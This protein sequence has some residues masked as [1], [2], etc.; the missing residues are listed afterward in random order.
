MKSRFII[1]FLF[2]TSFHLWAD[3]EESQK[4]NINFSGSFRVRG[5]NVGRDVL[6][7]RQTPV[8]RVTNPEAEFLSRQAQ[9]AEAINKDLERRRLG[10]PSELTPRREDISYYDTR[11]LYNMSFSASKYVEGIWGMQVGDI[12]F[13]GKGLRAT[14][15]DGFDPGIIGPGSGGERGRTAAVNVQ[16]NFLYL[17]FRIPEQA[18]FIKVGQQLF[19]SP[20]GRVLFSTGTGVSIVKNFQ[21]LRLVWDVG[22]LR[23]RDQSFLDVDK[24][25]FADKNYQNSNIFYN[26]MK[27]EYFRNIRNEFYAYLLDDNDKTDNETARLGWY[28]LFNEFNFQSFSF[29]VHG[30]L[31]TGTVRKLKSITDTNGLTV[32][33]TRSRHYIK[34]GMYDFQFTYRYSDQLNF[35]LIALGTTGR[36]GYDENGLEANLK[37]NGYRTLAPGFSISNIATDFTGGYALF[38]GSSFSGLNEYGAF[39]NLIAFGPYQFTF[40][41]YQLWATKSPEI[42]INREFSEWA[43]YKTST[44]LGMEYN[45]NIRYNVTS[46]FQIVFR[47]GYYVAGD[48]LFVLLDSKY[49][50][51]LREAFVTL[52]HRF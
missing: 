13:G 34:G 40:G 5:T 20:Q 48:A 30:I 7:T 50:R 21:F 9:D 24:N 31:N 41:Y 42:R 18:L 15:P 39:A 33:N 4:T 23:A 27:I 12:P 10:L 25:G 14:G 51:I 11:F 8:T 46:D 17:N 22:V 19:S 3:D 36:P 32:Y 43:G 1:L 37:G 38:N 49:G 52:E 6:L 2:V 28:G 16:T 35:N 44:Y 26:R 45:F 29:I 47:S